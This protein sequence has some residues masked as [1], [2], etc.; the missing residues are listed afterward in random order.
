MDNSALKARFERYDT[1]QNGR[2]DVAEFGRLVQSLGL[3][4][5]DAQIAAAFESIDANKSGVIDY[6]EFCRWWTQL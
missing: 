5:S 4:Y 1:D 6:D 3:G 2:I